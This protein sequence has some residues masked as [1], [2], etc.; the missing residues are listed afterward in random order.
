MK[1]GCRMAKIECSTR[2]VI[3]NFCLVLGLSAL[4]AAQ[5]R[6]GDAGGTSQSAQQESP[7]RPGG[8][9]K[10]AQHGE[11]LDLNKAS[12]ESLK[13]KLALTDAQIKNIVDHRPYKEKTDLLTRKIIS[14]RVYRRIENQIIVY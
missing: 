7:G 3:F 1:K 8:T 12:K 10:P 4:T 14:N 6:P 2:A 5:E 9:G 13:D 11:P